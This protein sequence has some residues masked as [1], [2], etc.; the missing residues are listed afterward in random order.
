MC[1][2]LSDSIIGFVSGCLSSV[3]VSIFFKNILG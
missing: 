2:L 3:F 1:E